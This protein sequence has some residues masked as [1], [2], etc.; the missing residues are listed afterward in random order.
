MSKA[1][2]SSSLCIS[3]EG[4]SFEDGL[5]CV[6]FMLCMY[7]QAKQRTLASFIKTHPPERRYTCAS[8]HSYSHTQI[9][10]LVSMCMLDYSDEQCDSIDNVE[11]DE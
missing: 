5:S 3:Y 9:V 1:E 4:N 10:E 6:C 2:D 11:V 8:V 7:A